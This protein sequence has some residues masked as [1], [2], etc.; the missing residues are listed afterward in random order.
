MTVS[1]M[2][3]K[4]ALITGA[5]SGIGWATA[6]AFAAK[7]ASVVM[8]ARRNGELAA[9]AQQIEAHGGKAT[10]VV[11]DVSLAGNV[12]RMVAHAIPKFGRLDYA[13][14]NAGYEG[15]VASIT[16]LSEEV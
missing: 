6:E 11:T 12:E 8:A 13:V 2:S 7:G 15:E 4:V 10:Y 9:L 1:D 3:G 5:S 14:N 16:E